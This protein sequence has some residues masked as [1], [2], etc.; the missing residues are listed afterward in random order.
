M[1]LWNLSTRLTQEV[2]HGDKRRRLFFTLQKYALSYM[3]FASKA[4]ATE[5]FEAK[6]FQ[7]AFIAQHLVLT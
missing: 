5:E 6:V 3:L 2:R 7:T 4:T 1:Y